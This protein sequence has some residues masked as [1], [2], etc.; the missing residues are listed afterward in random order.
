MFYALATYFTL[1]FSLD[2]AWL[3]TVFNVIWTS[4]DTGAFGHTVALE[5]L[6]VFFCGNSFW[7]FL[8]SCQM[9][10]VMQGMFMLQNI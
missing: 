9:G 10:S 6:R 2:E 5:V 3:T 1:S 8:L 4:E 7:T